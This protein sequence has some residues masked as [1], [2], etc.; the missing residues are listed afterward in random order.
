[1][2]TFLLVGICA[3]Y[4]LASRLPRLGIMVALLV[5]GMA[6]LGMGNGAVFQLVPQRFRLEIGAATGMVGALG[7]L[8]GFALP[9]LLGN[10]KQASGSF[11]AGFLTLA[12]VAFTA[13]I[14]LKLVTSVDKG[15]RF[16]WKPSQPVQTAQELAD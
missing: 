13:V 14:L 16:A 1:M 10:V 4:F 15:W 11:G 5:V 12:I 8:G 6:C 2:L 9:I 3:T 7:G